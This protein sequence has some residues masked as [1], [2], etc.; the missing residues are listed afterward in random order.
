MELEQ[1]ARFDLLVQQLERSLRQQTPSNYQMRVAAIAAIGYGYIWLICLVLDY[2]QACFSRQL[3]RLAQD[4]EIPPDIDRSP[5][6]KIR[7]RFRARSL[8]S[9][10]DRT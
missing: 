9:I 8:W 5:K 1:Q 10:A 3:D 7:L 4:R 6:P 2:L